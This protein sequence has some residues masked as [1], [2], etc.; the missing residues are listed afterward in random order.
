MNE[1]DNIESKLNRIT[2]QLDEEKWTRAALNSYTTTYFKE[3]D[4]IIDDAI[5]NNY[6]MQL[7]NLCDEHIMHTQNSI[8]AMYVSGILSLY[9]QLIDD[10]NI[11]KLIEIFTDNHKLQIVEGICEKMLTFGEQKLALKTLSLCY[12]QSN[13]EEKKYEIWERLI[14]IDYDEADI[15]KNIADRK[16]DDGKIEEAVDYYKKAL[17]RYINRKAFHN[18]KE[19]WNKLLVIDSEDANFFLNTEKKVAVAFDSEKATQ[20]LYDFYNATREKENWDLCISVLK[21]I[22]DYNP[23]DPDVR[24]QLI[25]CYKKK[26]EAHSKVENYIEKSELNKDWRNIHEAISDFE[27]HISFDAGTFVGHRTWGIGV[28]RSIDN[29]VLIIYFASKRNHPMSLDMAVTA[30]TCLPK[31]HIWVL[32]SVIDKKRLHDRV[33]SDP[34]W[35]LKT[36][37]SSFNNQASLK[38]IKTELV[39]SILTPTEWNTWSKEAKN[40]L[41]RDSEFGNLPDQTDVFTVRDTPITVEEKL[42]NNFKA[43]PKFYS[44]VKVMREFLKECQ[45]DSEYFNEMYTYF[46]SYLKEIDRPND[47]NVS[48]Y[49]LIREIVKEYPYLNPGIDKHF[50]DIFKDKNRLV[51]V[52]ERIEDAEIRKSFIRFVKEFSDWPIIYMKLFPKCLNRSILEDLAAQNRSD[53]ISQMFEEIAS[54]FREDRTAFIWLMKNAEEYKDLCKIQEETFVINAIQL[55]STLYKEMDNRY[56]VSEN[57]KLAQ[58][59]ESILFKEG[60]LEKTVQKISSDKLSKIYSL[61]NEIKGLSLALK[62]DVRRMISETHP[63]FQFGD[64][65]SKTLSARDIISRSLLVLQRSHQAKSRE[66]KYIIDVEIPNNS[67]EIGEALELGDLKENAEYK[68]AKE[69]QAILNATASKLQE[70]LEKAYIFKKEEINTSQIGFGTQ[71]TLQNLLTQKDESFTILGPWESDPNENIISYL[72]PFGKNLIGAKPGDTLEFEINEIPYKY[73]VKKIAACD[74]ID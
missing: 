20:L 10:S 53:C 55:L 74:N 6:A 52:F 70:D 47:I 42:Y 30:L 23:K 73:K 69:K 2:K 19:L 44:R 62:Q 7:K 3:L 50:K 35:A 38:Q 25:E 17:F 12:S 43:N 60:R 46:T 26:Y 49:I 1:N 24:K 28:I 37:I 54:N 39:P 18:V 34:H 56:N 5:E 64:E 14:K 27:K 66:L 48:A 57:R 63:E 41:D 59:I 33:K 71:V 61:V 68:A 15:V 9:F 22:V 4:A 72:S 40:I 31:N 36:V 29:E 45:P 16:K 11:T 8:I 65:Q 13:N 67:K 58:Q 21:R 51:S 32:K